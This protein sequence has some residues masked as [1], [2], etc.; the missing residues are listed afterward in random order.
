MLFPKLRRQTSQPDD[1][2][3]DLLGL[4]I[5]R[6][7][8]LH[9]LAVFFKFRGDSQKALILKVFG[10]QRHGAF[11]RGPNGAHL[12]LKFVRPGDEAEQ[13]LIPHPAHASP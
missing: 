4:D 5:A 8:P 9:V 13:R 2:L 7:M 6:V 3:P 12:R 11:K 10:Q 1:L